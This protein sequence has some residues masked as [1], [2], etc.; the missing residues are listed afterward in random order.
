[1][2]KHKIAGIADL[3]AIIDYDCYASLSKLLLNF[4]CK[5]TIDTKLTYPVR[6]VVGFPA[7]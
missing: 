4:D 5:I 6:S 2:A 1:M 7:R 3:T